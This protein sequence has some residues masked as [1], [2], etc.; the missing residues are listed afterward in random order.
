MDWIRRPVIS[1][2]FAGHWFRY[3]WFS[4]IV[5]H[6]R[7]GPFWS[8]YLLTSVLPH[9]APHPIKALEIIFYWERISVTLC[10]GSHNGT[11]GCMTIHPL[12]CYWDT[13]VRRRLSPLGW[14]S[15]V[16]AP[17][18][19]HCGARSSCSHIHWN[20]RFRVQITGIIHDHQSAQIW[21]EI[22]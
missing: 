10:S 8:T 15:I 3:F 17:R 16:L 20:N 6:V 11:T 5:H 19:H 1:W 14:E 2:S 12:T 18:V 4:L 7:L 9:L 13:D 21:I 22:I